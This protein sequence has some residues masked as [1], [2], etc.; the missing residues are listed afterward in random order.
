MKISN[1]LINAIAVLLISL[2]TLSAQEIIMPNSDLLEKQWLED[3][4]Y[5]ANFLNK[6]HPNPFCYISK[7]EFDDKIKILKEK[8]SNLT[9]DEITVELLKIITLIRDAHTML[10]GKSLSNKWFPVRIEAFPDGYYITSISSGYSNFIG[11]QVIK[12][13]KYPVEVAFERVK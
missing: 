7:E 1:I 4:D 11:S 6:T 2:F 13:E 10:H 8:V 9:T 3:I 5:M 12:V